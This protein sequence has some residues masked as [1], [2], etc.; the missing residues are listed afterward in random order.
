MGY[1]LEILIGRALFT[2]GVLS[3][4]LAQKGAGTYLLARE[5]ERGCLLFNASLQATFEA[6]CI[7]RTTC[8]RSH[9]GQLDLNRP[10]IS[11]TRP[12]PTEMC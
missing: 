5:R 11:G 10:P 12:Q 4:R 3:W 9:W 7:S 1:V 8:E 6:S 2:C